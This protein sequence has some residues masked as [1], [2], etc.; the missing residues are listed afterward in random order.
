MLRTYITQ[1]KIPISTHD[2][3]EYISL[4]E[5]NILIIKELFPWCIARNKTII[6]TFELMKIIS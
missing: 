5:K 2:R 4:K 1:K 6:E 3:M